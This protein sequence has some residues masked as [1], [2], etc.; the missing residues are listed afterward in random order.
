MEPSLG[1]GFHRPTRA[2]TDGAQERLDPSDAMDVG[3]WQ[4]PTQPVPGS[5]QHP[6]AQGGADQVNNELL[7][8]PPLMGA[9]LEGLGSTSTAGL[10]L[11]SQARFS[12][13]GLMPAF[14]NSVPA[15]WHAR[16][17]MPLRTTWRA[18]EGPKLEGARGAHLVAS[19][20]HEPVTAAQALS[21]AALK[22]RAQPVAAAP[23]VLQRPVPSLANDVLVWE[24]ASVEHFADH[25]ARLPFKHPCA[26]VQASSNAKGRSTPSHD[27]GD[28]H[29]KRI[30][31]SG[32][33]SALKRQRLP[34]AN[35]SD[36]D[37]TTPPPCSAA[38]GA[39]STA[40]SAASF[41][42][43]AVIAS[44]ADCTRLAR[45][46][47]L[48]TTTMPLPARVHATPAPPPPPP[49]PPSPPHQPATAIA[50]SSPPAPLSPH[51][52]PPSPRRPPR[53]PP[54]HLP[55]STRRRRMTTSRC[56]CRRR[57]GAASCSLAGISPGM[58]CSSVT[59]ASTCTS[60]S[61]SGWRIRLW[62]T[63]RRSG[64]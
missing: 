30:A 32:A 53:R 20:V 45:P 1:D 3:A 15:A 16:Q 56:C 41:R 23:K 7:R 51:H 25:P 12:G 40:G 61:P 44:A 2:R 34:G 37:F 6:H 60:A 50:T 10:T 47:V 11:P 31:P 63:W 24:D 36:A 57:Y 35:A 4:P 38:A 29:P 22:T 39:S 55:P 5:S 64:P 8:H 28:K 62:A 9:T 13:A 58:P 46:Q 26:L 21:R 43:R 54:R 14:E 17:E 52:P 42:P 49:L 33:G 27:D 18:E 59:H 19:T 48:T